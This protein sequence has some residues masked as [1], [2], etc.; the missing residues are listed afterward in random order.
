M[1]KL[2]VIIYVLTSIFSII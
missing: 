1:L 2:Y